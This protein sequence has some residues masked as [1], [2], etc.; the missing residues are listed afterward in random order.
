MITS[1]ASKQVVR[2]THLPTGIV[3][4]VD[5]NYSNRTHEQRQMAL[6]LLRSKL[7]LLKNTPEANTISYSFAD[8]E[9]YPDDPSDFKNDY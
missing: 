4:T 8:D 6:Q 1:R 9:P 3:V 2:I 5:S 7:F